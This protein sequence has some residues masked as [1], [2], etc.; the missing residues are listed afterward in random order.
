MASLELGGARTGEEGHREEM[1]ED[2]HVREHGAEV[3][4][5]FGVLLIHAGGGAFDTVTERR[6]LTL[7]SR[8]LKSVP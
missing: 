3:T 2:A 6:D 7:D 5:G 4:K 1:T 8:F